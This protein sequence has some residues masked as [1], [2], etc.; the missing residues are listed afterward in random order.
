MLRPK[1]LSAPAST[2]PE[3]T[4]RELRQRQWAFFGES[5]LPEDPEARQHEQR[6]RKWLVLSY[7]LCPCHLPLV[8]ALAGAALGGTAAGAAIVANT[9][10][11]G[12]ALSAAYGV[13]LWLGFREIR[14]AKALEAA[15]AVRC[16][17]GGCRAT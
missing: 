8:L 11:T 15:G 2:E 9:F 6:G 10:R 17:P 3:A 13:V 14:R 4:R 1:S 16:R 5:S 7:V 12:V